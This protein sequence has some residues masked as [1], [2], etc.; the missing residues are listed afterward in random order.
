MVTRKNDLMA[1]SSPYMR[2]DAPKTNR[3]L[4]IAFCYLGGDP[5]TGSIPCVH[6]AGQDPHVKVSTTIDSCHVK[7]P[8]DVAQI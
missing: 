5:I 8:N 7:G 2:R 1:N 4:T 6:H 3:W